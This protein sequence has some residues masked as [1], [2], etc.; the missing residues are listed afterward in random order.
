MRVGTALLLTCRRAY[1]ETHSLPLLQTEQRFYCHRGPSSGNPGGSRT[2]IGSFVKN[3]WG[4]PAPVPGL[5]QTDLVRSVRLFTQQFWLEDSFLS[6]VN[7]S[8]WFANLEHLRI[9]LRRS[10]WWDWERNATR[11]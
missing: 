11:K 8:I 6:F 2:D 9:T 1:L 4:N 3:L 10:D 5:R 7:T